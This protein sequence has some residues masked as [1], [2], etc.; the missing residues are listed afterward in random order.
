MNNFVRYIGA[1]V[2]SVTVFAVL[3][4]LSDAIS[5]ITHVKFDIIHTIFITCIIL[6]FVGKLKVSYQ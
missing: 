5:R 2:V 3:I 4:L 6:M 1:V